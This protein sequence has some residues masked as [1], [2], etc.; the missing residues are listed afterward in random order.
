[1]RLDDRRFGPREKRRCTKCGRSKAPHFFSRGAGPDSACR[2]C[3]NA[4]PV[5]KA[6]APPP[7]PSSSS[8]VVEVKLGKCRVMRVRVLGGVVVLTG[9]QIVERKVREA[10]G[11]GG[12]G[13]DTSWR[14]SRM[15]ESFVESGTL[16]IPFRALDEVQ[17]ALRRLARLQRKA[18]HPTQKPAP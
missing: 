14:V 6:A 7:P 12:G 9:G 1:M 17:A 3:R 15:S 13:N 4:G 18:E 5:V 2:R 10:W 11:R 8:L 16:T